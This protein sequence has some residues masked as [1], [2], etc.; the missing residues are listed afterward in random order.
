MSSQHK[1]YNFEVTP[2]AGA[3][4]R[5]AQELEG[6]NDYKSVSQ[7]LQ[8]LQ[9]PPPAFAW[10][11][12]SSELDDQKSFDIIAQKL[13]A[14]QV[15][16]PATVWQKIGEELD[17]ALPVVK[18]ETPVIP[19]RKRL[20]KYAVAAA[21]LGVL[22]LAGFYLFERSSK[23]AEAITKTF[24]DNSNSLKVSEQPVVK[25]Q[26]LNKTEATHIAIASDSA[27]HLIPPAHIPAE[28]DGIVTTSNGNSYT[29]SVEK[30]HEI[31]GRYIVLMTE[32]GNVVRM[33]KKV[34]GLADCIAGEDESQ[35]CNT[36]IEEWQKELASLPVLGSPDNILGLLELANKPVAGL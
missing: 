21:V 11:N 24:A 28:R 31:D 1:L 17:S 7:K 36:Q 32:E 2:P 3:W 25:E 10:N 34:S 9:V 6:V 14:A 4:E 26:P 35:Q 20:S 5:I 8:N 15:M 12:I 33:N 30:N 29:T 18:K 22:V 16:P 13:N 23:D 19:L 27:K